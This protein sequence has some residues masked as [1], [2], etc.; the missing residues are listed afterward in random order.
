M[1]LIVDPG[2]VSDGGTLAHSAE[3]V[4]DGTVAQADP[5]LVGTEVGHGDAAQVSAN[6]R[7]AQDRGVTG[8]RDSRLGLFIELGGGGE[9][10]GLVDLGL[11]ESSHE[12]EVTVP[13]GLKTFTGGQ[14]RDVELLVGITH[15]SVAGDH[16]VVDHSDE[17]LD[18]ED[19]VA[20]DETLDHVDL[21]AANLIVAVLLIPDSVLVEPVVGLGLGVERV[22]E[23]AGAGGGNPVHGAVRQQEVVD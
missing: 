15:V 19:V 3:L 6:G 17:G 10:V 9:G 14:L 16:L 4:V 2:E 7:A 11:G 12:D 5:A 21:G 23:V 18:T 1:D 20:E 8:V 22:A 13:G